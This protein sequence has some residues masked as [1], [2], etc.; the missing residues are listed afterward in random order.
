PT[1]GGASRVAWPPLRILWEPPP[2]GRIPPAALSGRKAQSRRGRRSYRGWGQ[3]GSLAIALN[4]VGAP[5]PGANPAGSSEWP[6]GSIAP[7]R[8]SYRGWGQPGSLGT[9][10]NIVGAP[11]PGATPSGSAGGPEGSSRPGRRSYRGWGQPGSLGTAP[12]IVGAPAPGANPAGSSEWP[13][14]SIAPGAALLQTLPG[15]LYLPRRL[16]YRPENSIS[17]SEIRPWLLPLMIFSAPAKAS[18]TPTS[19]MTS[20]SSWATAP[21]PGTPSATI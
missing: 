13:E 1:G 3:P 18:G 11:A 19:G 4:I 10:P 20:F 15:L 12:N 14:G 21:W 7:G 16:S 5:A 17:I 9:A 8:R 6:E 2:R